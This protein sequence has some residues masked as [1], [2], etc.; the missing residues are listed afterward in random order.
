M[1]MKD[2]RRAVVAKGEDVK[3]AFAGW[4]TYVPNTELYVVDASGAIRR[5]DVVAAGGRRALREANR[6]KKRRRVA[7]LK[8]RR[9]SA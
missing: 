2:L 8:S 7:E 1:N 3:K 6:E 5:R 9:A 4:K